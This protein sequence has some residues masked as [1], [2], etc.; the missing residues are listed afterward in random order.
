M[1]FVNGPNGGALRGPGN[2]ILVFVRCQRFS[3]SRRGQALVETAL[4]LPLLML[5]VMGSAD[6]GRVF[7]Y[8]IAVTNSAREAARQGTYYD[9]VSSGNVYD[10][11]AQVLAAAQQDV[12]SDVTLSLPAISPSHCLT[13]QPSS[14]SAYYPSQP[15]TGYVFI[16]F[17]GND[18]QSAPA[19]QTIQVTILYNFAPVTPLASVVGAAS[20]HVEAATMM[21]VQKQR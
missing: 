11:Y 5:L 3:Y 14:W 12:P 8:S 19:Q 15:N 17:D 20:V 16:C 21:Q 9:P 7:Y 1:A 4:L 10:S 6:L 18:S 13:G 2:R